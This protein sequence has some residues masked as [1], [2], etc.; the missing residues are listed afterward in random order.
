MDFILPLLPKGSSLAPRGA[1]EGSREPLQGSHGGATSPHQAFLEKKMSFYSCGKHISISPAGNASAGW[2]AGGSPSSSTGSSAAWCRSHT[3]A[4][5]T[6]GTCC[7][8]PLPQPAPAWQ[9]VHPSL[10]SATRC[11]PP[12]PIKE[13]RGQC[14]L[15][16]KSAL[17]RRRPKHTLHP[18]SS[19]RC[20]KGGKCHRC[21]SSSCVFTS[22]RLVMGTFLATTSHQGQSCS[23]PALGPTGCHHWLCHVRVLS[24]GYF[25]YLHLLSNAAISL[26]V[27]KLSTA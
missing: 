27:R 23:A 4:P 7:S 6:D 3:T 22:Q 1:L 14:L 12:F 9:R 18:G 17:L 5:S 13:W 15:A 24:S 11:Q 20:G 26:P 19:S 2:C 16:G 8:S 21:W 25:S 10:C